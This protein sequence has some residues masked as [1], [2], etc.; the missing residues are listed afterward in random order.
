MTY[1]DGEGVWWSFVLISFCI[2]VLNFGSSNNP[3]GSE[4]IA[5]L[6]ARLDREQIFTDNLKQEVFLAVFSEDEKDCRTSI[7]DSNKTA[8]LKQFIATADEEKQASE[9]AKANQNINFRRVFAETI[10]KSSDEYVCITS[11]SIPFYAV[12]RYEAHSSK[13]KNKMYKEKLLDDIKKKRIKDA[14]MF[15]SKN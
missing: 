8:E 9:I 11:V 6:K 2:V 13:H 12:M 7:T 10:A 14:D 5:E 15:C 3:C 4:T 1:S